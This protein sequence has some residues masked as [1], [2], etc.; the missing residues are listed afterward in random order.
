VLPDRRA[1]SAMAVRLG[2][3]AEAESLV[4]R[5]RRS[6]VDY[7]DRTTRASDPALFKAATRAGPGRVLG[8]DSVAQG[9]QV[10]RVVAIALPRPR[11]FAEVRDEVESRYVLE[12]SER[13][14]RSLIERLR[15]ETRITI[16][17]EMLRALS[18]SPAAA[19]AA[20]P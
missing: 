17:R 19:R 13:R 15:R 1:A 16:D 5:A 18:S 20:R 4:A 3:A 12:E 11:G 10:A 7:R 2:D 8:P 9:W 14:T 6:G